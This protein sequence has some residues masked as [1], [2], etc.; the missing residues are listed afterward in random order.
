[1]GFF[2]V[3][4]SILYAMAS[5]VYNQEQ[6]YSQYKKINDFVFRR[7]RLFFYDLAHNLSCCKTQNW[8]MNF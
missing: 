4:R 8:S 2:E 5:K 7:L 6:I 3:N 1:M